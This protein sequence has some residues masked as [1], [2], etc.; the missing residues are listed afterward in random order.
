MNAT[1][2]LDTSLLT[3]RSLRA[4]RRLPVFLFVT[5]I[6]P[7]IWLLLFGQLFKSV[8]QIPGFHAGS[9]SFLQF[10]TP[11]IIM[12]TALFGGAW[13]GTTYIQDMDRGVMDR[14]LT[15]PV[16]RGSMM[17]SNLAYQA[18]SIIIQTVVIL[19]IAL[20]MGARFS[21]GI[22]GVL[23][24][25]VAAVL[26]VVIFSALS[27]AIALLVRQ[28]QALIGLSQLTTLPLMFL[29]SAVMD[30]SLAPSWVRTIARFNPVEWAIVAGRE[31]MLGN[32]DWSMVWT[33]LGL[34]AVVALLMGW[35]ATRAFRAYQRSA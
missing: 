4:L 21:G 31:A 19:G 15:S 12:M 28:Q 5:L 35:V 24:A 34:L 13:A 14:L 6:Q 32:T 27:N 8:V 9:G 23:V 17:I 22:T 2:I 18:I 20:A 16:S 30:T 29:S 10:L 3:A 1:F 7:M 33:R 25:M 26:L 11:G